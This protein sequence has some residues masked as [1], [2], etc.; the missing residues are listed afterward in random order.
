M[1]SKIVG[2][3]KAKELIFTGET[4]SPDEALRFGLVNFVEE[5]SIQKAIKLAK[6][7]SEN[8]PL[9]IKAAKEMI[10]HSN[11]YLT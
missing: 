3:A 11:G 1:L 4:I 7:I 8:G 6:K 10:N 9:G 2:I 5:D